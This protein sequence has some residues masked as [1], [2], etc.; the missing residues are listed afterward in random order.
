MGRQMLTAAGSH[1]A[2]GAGTAKN[3]WL[4]QT[5]FQDTASGEYAR[6]R[7]AQT[8]L[9]MASRPMLTA[10][11]TS[12]RNAPLARAALQIPTANQDIAT[13]FY[14]YAHC[15]HAM[16]AYKMETRQML[17][18]AGAAK[19]AAQASHAGRIQIA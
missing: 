17:T 11:D 10:A 18:A 12:A 6:M 2:K 1:N 4:M 7:P 8:R 3:A 14:L 19:D 16:T 5:A 9:G 15:Q 13:A